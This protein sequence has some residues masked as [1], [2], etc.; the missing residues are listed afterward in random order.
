MAHESGRW[1]CFVN[2]VMNMQFSFQSVRTPWLAMD[3]SACQEGPCSME[4]VIQ[5]VI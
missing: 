1:L 4:L 5:S 2:M 3:L